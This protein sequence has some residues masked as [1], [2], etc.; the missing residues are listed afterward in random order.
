MKQ[1]IQNEQIVCASV[2]DEREEILDIQSRPQTLAH[3][4]LEVLPLAPQPFHDI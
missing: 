1:Y 4:N 3:A 2:H